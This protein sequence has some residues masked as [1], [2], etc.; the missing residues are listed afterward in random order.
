MRMGRYQSSH[1]RQSASGLGGEG[2]EEIKK[3]V[4]GIHTLAVHVHMEILGVLL[5]DGLWFNKISLKISIQDQE[6]QPDNQLPAHGHFKVNRSLDIC[7]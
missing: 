5:Q 1:F 7:G 4:E 2:E 3:T 6:N